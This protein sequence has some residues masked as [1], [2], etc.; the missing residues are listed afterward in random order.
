MQND[1]FVCLTADELNV[2][3]AEGQGSVMPPVHMSADLATV[4]LVETLRVG[5]A[6]LCVA[7][8]A[9]VVGAVL[10][11]TL[12]D[13]ST[14][15]E[16]PFVGFGFACALGLGV[17][18]ML[19]SIPMWTTFRA[20]RTWQRAI[21][22]RDLHYSV[23]PAISEGANTTITPRLAHLGRP[24]AQ[25]VITSGRL[26]SGMQLDKKTGIISGAPGLKEGDLAN[27]PENIM[28]V[29]FRVTITATNIKGST[30]ARIMIPVRATIAQRIHAA[31]GAHA[32]RETSQSIP[33][34]QVSLNN[35]VS[36]TMERAQVSEETAAQAELTAEQE[37]R[38]NYD[39]VWGGQDDA[40]SRITG[41]RGGRGS[42]LNTS[43]TEMEGH[44]TGF[45]SSID[46]DGRGET[47]HGL[48]EM[49]V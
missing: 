34:N 9:L 45:R 27:A 15:E 33:Q 13:P 42:S 36:V 2:K 6:V 4:L 14:L 24:P 21:A 29:Q 48:R 26:P 5:A 43:E 12:G 18:A 46:S 1:W 37:Q 41:D 38:R 10:H 23:P 39:S 32:A 44:G 7:G 3:G 30:R 49:S 40:E 28:E 8:G 11:Q 35:A 47:N 20:I 22:P 16:D 19:A 17:G 31:T 25:F